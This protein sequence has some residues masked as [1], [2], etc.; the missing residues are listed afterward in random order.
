MTVA[1]VARRLD[2]SP[3]EISRLVK[4]HW[5][6]LNRLCRV[7]HHR[8]WVG[9]RSNILLGRVHLVFLIGFVDTDR[10]NE[11]LSDFGHEAYVRTH[12]A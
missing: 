12:R 10:A 7:P 3:D 5:R 2:C 4:V 6:Q 1:D 9:Q 11:L 8:N